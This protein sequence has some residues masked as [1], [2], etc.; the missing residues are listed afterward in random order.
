MNRPDIRTIWQKAFIG[1]M[2]KL[3][4]TEPLYWI[5]DAVDESKSAQTLLTV[6]PSLRELRFPIRVVLIS[7]PF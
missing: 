3:S 5:M 6:I 2:P 7:G 1:I 4:N